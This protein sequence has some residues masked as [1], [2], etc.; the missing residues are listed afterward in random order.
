MA[1][2]AATLQGSA[3]FSAWT[4]Q[5]NATTLVAYSNTGG[6]LSQSSVYTDLTLITT[7]N[8]YAPITLSAAGWTF[9]NGVLTRA[10]ETWSATGVWS[11]VMT[12]Y[13]ITFGSVLLMY[14]DLTDS[15]DVPAPFTAAAGKKVRVDLTTVL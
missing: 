14:R 4:L 5:G 8:G 15:G 1:N 12:G 6:T 3:Q 2:Q 7:A 13:A 11:A 10:N 9:S